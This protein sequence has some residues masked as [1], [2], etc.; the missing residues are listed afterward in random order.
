MPRLTRR[1]AIGFGLAL[2]ARPARAEDL[3]EPTFVPIELFEEALEC[4]SAVRLG[5][6]SGDVTILEVFDHNCPWCRHSAQDLAPLLA[7]DPDLS[8]VL[9][10]TPILGE[11]SLGAARVAQAVARLHGP[12]RAGAYHRA[13]MALRGRLDGERAL[14][15]AEHV[16][17]DRAALAAAA[18]SSEV[19][20][21][22]E[23]ALR[24][25]RS[26]GI[27]ATPSF[28]LGPDLYPGALT[29]AQK[30]ALVARARA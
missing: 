13:L 12:E 6:P 30:Q 14:A 22:V 21:R 4:E 11:A 18:E 29:L 8:Y 2:L 23:E 15:Q 10:C 3:P 5:N 27:N 1:A 28:V 16:G 26:L 17:L 9:L 20:H 7:G 19:R 25:G 24:I